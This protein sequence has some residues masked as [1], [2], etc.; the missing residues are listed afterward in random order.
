M[1]KTR[2]LVCDGHTMIRAGVRAMLGHQPDLEV[3]AEASTVDE[4]M[5][6]LRSGRPDVAV[7]GSLATGIRLLR[8]TEAPLWPHQRQGARVVALTQGED[9]VEEQVEILL[10]VRLG[11]SGVVRADAPGSDLVS[12]VRSAAAG[13][14]MLSPAATVGLLDWVTSVL[15]SDPAA[16]RRLETLSV[17]EL[18]V[19]RL[20]AEGRSS[21]EIAAALSVAV[22]TVRSHVHHLLTKLGLRD[23]VEAVVFAYQHGL[24]DP[25]TRTG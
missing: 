1:T 13:Q 15:P 20:I 2:V 3:V 18:E 22:V 4:A 12:A 24:V 21:Q 9:Q 10:A 11:L 25:P 5:V 14:V 7:V 23:R 19:L 17:R 16:S 8:D 6:L